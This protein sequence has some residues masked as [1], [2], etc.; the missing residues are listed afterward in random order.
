M[1]HHLSLPA[2]NPE[3]VASV[4]AEIFGG[5]AT[6]IP[7]SDVW[8]AWSTDVHGTAVEIFP[9]GFTMRPGEKDQPVC[10]GGE[11][12]PAGFIETHAAISV[13]LTTE[14]LLDIAEREGWQA[15]EHDRGPFRV[16]EFWLENTVLIE[17]LTPAMR[18]EYT[19]AVTSFA[20]GDRN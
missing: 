17:F 15:M 12:V 1:I 20:G 2:E 6:L 3:H 5:T 8:A 4:L 18:D 11:Q 10:M 19:S 14:K 13:E 7:G 16:V 9:R